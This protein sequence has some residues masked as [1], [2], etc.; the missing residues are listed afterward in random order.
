MSKFGTVRI[1]GVSRG[2]IKNILLCSAKQTVFLL[3]GS[4]VVSMVKS[5]LVIKSSNCVRNLA[6][7]LA[8]FFMI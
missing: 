2:G 3:N 1:G 7:S 8:E 6:Y 4:L 5:I